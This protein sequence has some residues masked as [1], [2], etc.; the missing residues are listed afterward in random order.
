MSRQVLNTYRDPEPC[1]RTC[2]GLLNRLYLRI[3]LSKVE[4]ENCLGGHAEAFLTTCI[5]NSPRKRSK[6]NDSKENIM[7]CY[8]DLK[9]ENIKRRN[10]PIVTLVSKIEILM[11]RSAASGKTISCSLLCRHDD[12]YSSLAGSDLYR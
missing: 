6:Q 5:A 3:V 1:T 4:S 9:N 7:M 11:A 12:L 8:P 10:I 2:E